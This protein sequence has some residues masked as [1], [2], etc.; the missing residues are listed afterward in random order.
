MDEVLMLEQID[1]GRPPSLRFF[2]SILVVLASLIGLVTREVSGIQ[3]E[4][5]DVEVL[6]DVDEDEDKKFLELIVVADD[7]AEDG[8]T[9][10]VFNVCLMLR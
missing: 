5:E 2:G 10:E 4:D 6:L 1:C 8:T 3:D 9:D 7:D